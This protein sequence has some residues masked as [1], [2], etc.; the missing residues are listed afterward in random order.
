[1]G[2]FEEAELRISDLEDDLNEAYDIIADR[3]R[4][5]EDMERELQETQENLDDVQLELDEAEDDLMRSEG[6]FDSLQDEYDDLYTN[7]P[8]DM[9]D[10][11]AGAHED[12]IKETVELLVSLHNELVISDVQFTKIM[13]E[14]TVKHRISKII[15]G[16]DTK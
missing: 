14:I 10:R 12:G 7:G 2:E 4:D 1:M 16:Y 5:L 15:P 6:D 11:I 3:D 8:D 9:D 13:D